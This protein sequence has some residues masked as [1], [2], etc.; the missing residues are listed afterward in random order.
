MSEEKEGHKIPF[1]LI[2]L[3]IFILVWAALAWI[4]FNKY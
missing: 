4:P 2:I 3:Y 1:Y